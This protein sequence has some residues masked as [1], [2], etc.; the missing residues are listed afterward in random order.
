MPLCRHVLWIIFYG[1][2]A[3]HFSLVA[4]DCYFPNGLLNEL[5]QPCNR[6]SAHSMCCGTRGLDR[7]RNDG[8]CFDAPNNDMWR[9]SCSDPTWKSPACIKLCVEGTGTL[10]IIVDVLV[11]RRR[12]RSPV[13]TC[14]PVFQARMATRGLRTANESASVGME[15]SV[16]GRD[17][18]PRAAAMVEGAFSSPTARSLRHILLP[19]LRR[20]RA[21]SRHHG[22][23]RHLCLYHP[24]LQYRRAIP[25]AE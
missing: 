20:A 4:A 15:A 3:V 23:R 16:V 7:C 24:S 6:S 9:G 10:L 1:S 2:T 18:T 21:A 19:A 22:R 5:Y 11:R 17:P 14:Q 25:P 8:L 13:P 12:I